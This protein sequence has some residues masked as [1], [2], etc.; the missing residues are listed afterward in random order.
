MK[1]RFIFYLFTL[2]CIGISVFFIFNIIAIAQ[3]P[4]YEKCIHQS[5]DSCIEYE[6]SDH[7]SFTHNFFS[8]LGSINTNTDD[9]TYEGGSNNKA[10]TVSMIFFN[11]SLV[12]VGAVLIIFYTFFYKFFIWKED[13]QKSIQYSRFCKYIGIITGIMFIG[14]GFVPHD[15]HFASHVFLAKWAFATLLPL[16]IFHALSFKNSIYIKNRYSFGYILFCII[17]SIYV[18]HLYL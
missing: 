9:D 3:Y 16:S 8:E 14:V 11:G 6:R 15:L 2:P 18:Y 13:S 1:K 5:I 7:Y 4:G 10:N 17:L 12:C